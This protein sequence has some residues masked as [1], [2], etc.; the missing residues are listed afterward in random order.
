MAEMV[1]HFNFADLHVGWLGLSQVH[2]RR[3]GVTGLGCVELALA[4]GMPNSSTLALC[5]ESESI[6]MPISLIKLDT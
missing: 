2:V 6:F 1:I 5:A 3:N 4:C